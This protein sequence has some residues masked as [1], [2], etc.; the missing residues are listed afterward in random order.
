MPV[1]Q[2]AYD[3]L[4]ESGLFFAW[5]RFRK[6]TGE[7]Q[8]QQDYFSSCLPDDKDVTRVFETAQETWLHNKG[9]SVQGAV[10]LG[11]V[12]LYSYARP[13]L[14]PDSL[15]NHF[16]PF[17]I[18][19]KLRHIDR[20]D[21][22]YFDSHGHIYRPGLE[23]RL[24][25]RDD[26]YRLQKAVAPLTPTY[27]PLLSPLWRLIFRLYEYLLALR[28]RLAGE[29]VLAFYCA[30]DR[31]YFGSVYIN[32]RGQFFSVYSHT[33]EAIECGTRRLISL[34]SGT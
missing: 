19:D 33:R 8:T 9:N 29:K 17:R 12:R 23:I 16:S 3:A 18:Y 25:T 22:L 30:E 31:T 4:R 20:K 27:S 11:S 10:T 6:K 21:S 32:T 24:P 5:A 26:A 7:G 28:R 14:T 1:F 13:V 2:P 15:W 34:L